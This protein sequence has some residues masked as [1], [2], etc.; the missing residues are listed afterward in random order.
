MKGKIKCALRSSKDHSTKRKRSRTGT[1]R[2]MGIP[3]LEAVALWWRFSVPHYVASH[4]VP[5][6]DIAPYR[7]SISVSCADPR[8]PNLCRIGFLMDLKRTNFRSMD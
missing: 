8:K 4:S 5:R 6:G 3:V 1:A 7:T 2:F